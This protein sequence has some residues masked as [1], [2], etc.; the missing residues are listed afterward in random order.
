MDAN[1]WSGQCS[2]HR[3]LR[4]TPC[5]TPGRRSSCRPRSRACSSAASSLAQLAGVRHIQRW[6]VPDPLLRGPRQPLRN[7][8]PS[9]WRSNSTALHGHACEP[10]AFPGIGSRRDVALFGGFAASFF[11]RAPP[12]FSGA[13]LAWVTD[14]ANARLLQLLAFATGGP[15]PRTPRRRQ[16]RR[17]L[18]PKTSAMR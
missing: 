1:D 11:L 10:T 14:G 17:R 12:S 13:R 16:Y 8:V 2:L 7:R 9:V 4:L 6:N 3:A 5:L 15:G 18:D